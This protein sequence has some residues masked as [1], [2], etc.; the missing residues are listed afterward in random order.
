[1]K[2]GITYGSVWDWKIT[3]KYTFF[4]QLFFSPQWFGG[5][6]EKVENRRKVKATLI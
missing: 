5:G 1:L 6:K 4:S 2:N 3:H